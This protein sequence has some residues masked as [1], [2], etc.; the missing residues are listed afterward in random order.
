MPKRETN[1]WTAERIWPDSIVFILGGGP[2]LNGTNFDLIKDG[3]IIAVNNA[4]QLGDWVDVVWF[5]DARWYDWHREQLKSFDGLICHC[6]NSVRSPVRLKRLQR[7]KSTG[8]ERR[9]HSVA[10][11]RSSGASAINLAYHLGAKTVVLLGFDMKRK[12]VNGKP[13]NNWHEDHKTVTGNNPYPRFLSVFPMIK[14]DAEALGLEI[15]N[16]TPN[17]ELKIFPMMS[18][19]EFVAVRGL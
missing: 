5:G 18:L 14:K 19:E 13:K 16:C 12:I 10:W 9:P 17:S 7:G 1:V 8:I 4:Y 2:S 15:I 6:A 3:H 11:N